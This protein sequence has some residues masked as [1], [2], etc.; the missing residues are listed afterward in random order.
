MHPNESVVA[1]DMNEEVGADTTETVE[2]AVDGI[3]Y[4]VAVGK[5]DNENV[6]IIVDTTT[7]E[8]ENVVDNDQ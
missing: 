3:D 4:N 2:A 6:N 5:V 1:T 7:S 8:H